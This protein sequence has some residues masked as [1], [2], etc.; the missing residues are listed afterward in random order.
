[1]RRLT[2][3]KAGDK[4]GRFTVISEADKSNT[5]KR[6]WLCICDCGNERKVHQYSLHI[7]MSKSCGCLQRETIAENRYTTHGM[8]GT[9]IYKRWRA[10]VSRCR[11]TAKHCRHNYYDRGISVCNEWKNDP[12]AFI[13]W[14]LANGFREDLELDRKDNSGNYTPENAHFV[15]RSENGR[16]R[17][18]NLNVTYKGEKMT[19]VEFAERFAACSLS[20][21]YHRY[22]HQWTLDEIRHT[23]TRTKRNLTL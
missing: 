23:P 5:G 12:A 2:C 11:P 15:T 8:T 19:F 13:E 14:A 1:M 10:M 22:Y 18:D 3:V 20:A 6:R 16:N 9:P 17:R 21:A 7:G 4:Y